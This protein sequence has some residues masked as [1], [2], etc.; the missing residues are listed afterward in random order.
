VR[1]QG[2]AALNCWSGG[3]AKTAFSK[4]ADY[5]H[6]TIVNHFYNGVVIVEVSRNGLAVAILLHGRSGDA[7]FDDS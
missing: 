6:V 1:F 2:G 7:D 3:A 4:K 5:S